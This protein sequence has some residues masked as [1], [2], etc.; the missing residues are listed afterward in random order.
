MVVPSLSMETPRPERTTLS[1]DWRSDSSASP[2]AEVVVC[3]WR[4]TSSHASPILRISSAAFS[5]PAATVS[6]ILVIASVTTSR[7]LVT[8]AAVSPATMPPESRFEIFGIDS[9][10]PSLRPS[11]RPA[12]IL[13]PDS[14]GFMESMYS[15]AC[16]RP[17]LA[18]VA[19]I[20]ES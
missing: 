15:L 10:K 12:A 11:L 5:T 17:A 19:R 2:E 7:P 4:S 18:H 3:S 14:R 8:K 13:L 9:P 6:T 16:S 1:A 20:A